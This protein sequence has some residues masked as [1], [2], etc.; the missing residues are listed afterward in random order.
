MTQ[1]YK[2]RSVDLEN[3]T[4]VVEFDGLQPLNMWIPHDEQ[5]FLVGEALDIAIQQMYPW[6]AA[7]RDKFKTFT[8]GAE[9][10]SLVEPVEITEE[11]IRQERNFMLM[12]SDWTQVEDAPLTA[13]QK[14]NWVVYRQALRD[15]TTQAGFP[16]NTNWPTQPV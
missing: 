8:N 12:R 6:D 13:E 9:L 3:G 4:F 14:S 11:Q 16:V 5:G 15:I 10:Q 2:I 1:Q 7:Q